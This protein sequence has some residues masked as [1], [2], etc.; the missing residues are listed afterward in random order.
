MDAPAAPQ[1]LE[2]KSKAVRLVTW[3]TCRECG[4]ESTTPGGL[5]KH[6]RRHEMDAWAY[7]NR[8]LDALR[9]R[10]LSNVIEV[11]RVDGLTPCWEYQGRRTFNKTK[12]G[13]RGYCQMRIA[14][15]PTPAV[16]RL[17]MLAFGGQLPLDLVLHQCDNPICCN[18][19][20]LRDGSHTENM[21]ERSERSRTAAGSRHYAAA[22]DVEAV[23][24]VRQRASWG[25]SGAAIARH[26]E[27][28]DE[29]VCRI[30]R[31]DTYQD[32]QYD[33]AYDGDFIPW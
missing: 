26:L 14:G 30:L 13:A 17:S 33:P 28:D 6:I 31:G 15:A 24:G 2:V 12:P 22:L 19:A 4:R 1:A 5:H 25:W 29:V 10:I 21:A 3:L 23:Q 11:Q 32:V 8:H 18:P 20:H 27:V 7:Y 9:E 16:H